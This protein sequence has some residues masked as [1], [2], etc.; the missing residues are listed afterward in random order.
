MPRKG[1]IL[2]EFKSFL[3]TVGGNEGGKCKYPSRLDTYGC[4]CSHDCDYC[5]AR[6]LLEF[7]GLWNPKE[8]AVADINKIRKK[9]DK[10][11]PGTILRLGGM[12]DCFQPIEATLHVTYQ[13]IIELNKRGIGYLIVT[14][15]ALI[16]DDA[17]IEVLDRNLAHIQITITATDDQKAL[18]YEKASPISKRIQA[19]EKLQEHGFDVSVR[20]SPFI[21][22]YIDYDVLNA[23]RCDKILVEFL[24]SNGFIRKTFPIDYSKYTVKQSGYWHLPLEEKIKLLENITGFKELTV[25]E[26]ETEA[27][28]YWKNSV[29][30]NPD[31]CCNLRL[32]V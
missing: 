28:E 16:A 14:K 20:L 12:T 5:Y 21:P 17:Y 13:T 27:Y 23:I 8:P 31:D 26:D 24:R 15:S 10:V 25:C 11:K 22:E 19:I 18:E 6:S 9:L 3:K 2:A 30:P 32:S 7:R 29:N 1:Y 4:G